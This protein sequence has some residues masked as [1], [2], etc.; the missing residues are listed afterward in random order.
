MEFIQNDF[1][2]KELRVSPTRNLIIGKN[3]RVQIEPRIMDVLCVL[4]Q[5]ARDVVSR[6]DFIEQIWKVQ[7][8]G[9]ESLTRAISLL[10]KTFKKFGLVPEIIETIPKRGYR[11]AIEISDRPSPT[12][13]TTQPS[14]SSVSPS[15]NRSTQS[16][17]VISPNISTTRPAQVATHP[18]PTEPSVQSIPVTAFKTSPKII[19]AL[20]LFPMLIGAI[21]V[22]WY[23]GQINTSKIETEL[24]A[25]EQ[26]LL[27]NIKIEAGLS[28]TE[29][30]MAMMLAY[31]EGNIGKQTAISAAER[32]LQ[33]ADSD[34]LSSEVMTLS[35]KAWLRYHQEN[36]NDSLVLF[37]RAIAED[38]IHGNSWLGKARVLKDIKNYE[39]ALVNAD[40]AIR[41]DP[42]SFAARLLRAEI[43]AAQ[44]K[45]D[46]ASVEIDS[47]LKLNS[48]F[49]KALKFQEQLSI[50][51]Y[52][53][54]DRDGRL[55]PGEIG[56][57]DTAL[58]QIQD[59]DDTLG[60]SIDEFK[61]RSEAPLGTTTTDKT[62][63]QYD[64]S[65]PKNPKFQKWQQA[66]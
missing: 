37:E 36:L 51:R 21:F 11:L 1:M 16:K 64:L 60:I 8:G 6:E 26:D 40:Q 33:K 15:P 2:I 30:A 52:Y 25:P 53:D 43:L 58:H 50:F 38:P 24:D 22:G 44:K 10:R 5:N 59:Q 41:L 34:N 29:I 35:A 45:M 23:I 14:P 12:I 62:L 66:K 54:T 27:A 7:F 49:P 28:N 3:D 55:L 31:D 63:F 4:S 42:L 47:L 46:E 9:D 18:I 13:T 56:T 65:D 32:Y 39:L 17:A 61:V 48:Q 57:G 19:R 20:I